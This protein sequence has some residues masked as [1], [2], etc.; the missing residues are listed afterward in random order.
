MVDEDSFK[1]IYAQFFP[2]GGKLISNMHPPL[3][4]FMNQGV[5]VRF[6]L[7]TMCQLDV[8]TRLNRSVQG[9]LFQFA[10]MISEGVYILAACIVLK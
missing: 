8:A 1:G 5:I 10:R 6:P 2:Q 7:K 4:T 9:Q 3:I